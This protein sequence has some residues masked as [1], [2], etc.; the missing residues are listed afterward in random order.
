MRTCGQCEIQ[1]KHDQT[2]YS[3]KM[4]YVNGKCWNAFKYMLE[5]SIFNEVNVFEAYIMG[6]LIPHQ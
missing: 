2:K 5:K 1:L 6:L 3:W 4:K